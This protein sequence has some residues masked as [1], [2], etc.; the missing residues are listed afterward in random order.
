MLD[1]SNVIASRDPQNALGVAAAEPSQLNGRLDIQNA[2]Q[3]AE[4]ENII[5]AGMGGSALAA[6]LAKSWLQ[7]GVPFEVVRRYDLPRYVGPKTL[8]IASSHSGNTEETL[9]AFRGA[10][11]IGAKVAVVTSGGKLTEEATAKHLPIV[12][13]L[14]DLEP[15]MTVFSNLKAL[16]LLLEAYGIV[17]SRADDL[18]S[19]AAWLEDEV[20][21]WH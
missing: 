15:R 5:V 10:L 3:G 11:A 19:V 6:G 13:I 7:L 12:F 16:A 14:A 9:E 1:D 2:P 4:F 21:N 8:V 20:R 17:N 18:E